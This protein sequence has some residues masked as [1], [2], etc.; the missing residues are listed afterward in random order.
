MSQNR[1]L[2]THKPSGS[3]YLIPRGIPLE[4]GAYELT[5]T[6]GDQIQV[7]QP[8]IQQYLATEAESEQYFEG[9]IQDA[10][11]QVGSLFK[12]LFQMGAQVFANKA[13]DELTDAFDQFE[14]SSEEDSSSDE[15]EQSEDQAGDNASD[16]V[17]RLHADKNPTG[18]LLDDLV[19]PFQELKNV[20]ADGMAEIKT[21]FSDLKKELANAFESPEGQDALR[22]L[23]Q[24]I[25]DFA[26]NMN[27]DSTTPDDDNAEQ[28]SSTA[29]TSPVV[30]VETEAATEEAPEA[31]DS[32]PSKQQE[33]PEPE[34]SADSQPPVVLPSPSALA[35]MKKQELIDFAATFGLQLTHKQK[36]AELLAAI[37]SK[38]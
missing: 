21:A 19:D 35:K 28:V 17:H 1:D 33:G 13:E 36:K 37:E 27:V 6:S 12:D 25:T 14:D 38:R 15:S 26:N 4:V 31:D 7:T 22:D 3:N 2:W 20:F 24:T 32:A 9:Q 30:E 18:S 16:N 34:T 11:G 29:Q 23:G 5:S 8:G 10:L